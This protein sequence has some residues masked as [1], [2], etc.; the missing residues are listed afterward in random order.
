M[1]A[2]SHLRQLIPDYIETLALFIQNI[3]EVQD[4]ELKLILET[5]GTS[6]GS[7]VQDLCGSGWQVPDASAME[8]LCSMP[9]EPLPNNDTSELDRRKREVPGIRAHQ[10]AGASS[11]GKARSEQRRAAIQSRRLLYQVHHPTPSHQRCTR[12][13]REVLRATA[14]P[15]KGTAY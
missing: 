13:S 6:S 15:S 7:V 9:R 3:N 11:R 5:H 12:N 14:T 1:L 4:I 2:A 10:E 8:R